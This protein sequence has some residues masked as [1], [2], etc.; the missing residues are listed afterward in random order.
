MTDNLEPQP[1]MAR[2][3]KAA[4]TAEEE[5]LVWVADQ[6]TEA[7]ATLER[8]ERE[9]AEEK[10]R[11]FQ[12]LRRTE[13]LAEKLLAANEENRRLAALSVPAEERN[14][15]RCDCGVECQDLGAAGECRYVDSSPPE[16]SA[17]ANR[18]TLAR[19]IDPE[20]W[21]DHDEVARLKAFWGSHYSGQAR[22]DLSLAKADAI[23]ALAPAE[24]RSD[25]AVRELL[26]EAAVALQQA[27]IRFQAIEQYSRRLGP[28]PAVEAAHEHAEKVLCKIAEFGVPTPPKAEADHG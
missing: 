12:R 13:K 15:A 17:K 9:L 6:M 16:S 11:S 28:L 20:I 7:A 18:E 4:M 25:Q 26:R 3:K 10:A 23:L 19:I 5:G 2:L 14:S 21:A 27:C 22:I 1:L 24:A 8:A